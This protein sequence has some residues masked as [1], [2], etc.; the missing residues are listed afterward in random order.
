M[1]RA[2]EKRVFALIAA[3]GKGS[4]M[5]M[6]INKQYIEVG[7]IPILARTIQ[8][9]EDCAYVNNIVIVVNESD[10]MYCKQH[11]ID[12]YRFQKVTTVVAGGQTR[13]QSVYNGLVEIGELCSIVLIH[14]GARPFI[15]Q[16]S[17]IDSIAAADEFGGACVAVPVKDTIKQVN[18]DGFIEKTF[19]RSALWSV[20]TPQTFR[21]EIIMDAYENAAKAGFVATDDAMLAE[22]MGKLVR[23]V[24]GSYYNIKITTAEDL[25]LA[26]AIAARE[27]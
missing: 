16:E 22:R 2:V 24:Q 27:V 6:D 23:I 14:D 11:I 20:Q 10:I 3:A 1:N 12:A 18:M 7:G 9:F 5:N 8:A 26:E 21:Y 25:I 17:I 4:R 19:D 13:Q 15:S